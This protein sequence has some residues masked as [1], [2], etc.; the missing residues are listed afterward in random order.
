VWPAG[1]EKFT[2]WA[3]AAHIPVKDAN[4]QSHTLA[5]LRDT[6]LPQLLSGELN[7]AGDELLKRNVL[8]FY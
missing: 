3:K 8:V 6:L 1:L 4:Q 5:T 2:A 7:V